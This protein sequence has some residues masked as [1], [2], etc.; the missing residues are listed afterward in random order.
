MTRC[1]W[2]SRDRRSRGEGRVGL[3]CC[4]GPNCCLSG[5][6]IESVKNREYNP[7]SEHSPC[8]EPSK[9]VVVTLRQEFLI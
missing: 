1:Q 8:V 4:K 3:L 7:I 6:R 5:S 9:K 2:K